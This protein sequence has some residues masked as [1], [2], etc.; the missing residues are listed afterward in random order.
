[1]LGLAISANM[2][3]GLGA[4]A[5]RSRTLQ[6][7]VTAYCDQGQTASGEQTRRGIVAADPD[8]LPIGSRIRVDGLA[9]RHNGTYDVKDTGSA[10]KGRIIDIFMRDCGAAKRFGRQTARVQVLRV[11]DGESR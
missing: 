10:V 5:Q 2:A 7:E 4:T 9:G 3:C 1:M 6:V 8:V 11:G